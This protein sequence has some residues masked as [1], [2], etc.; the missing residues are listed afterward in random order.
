[1]KTGKQQLDDIYK[2]LVHAVFTERW[3]KE[4]IPAIRNK[5]ASGRPNFYPNYRALNQLRRSDKEIRDK[6][7]P[8]AKERKIK[9]DATWTG[10]KILDVVYEALRPEPYVIE[11]REK[12]GS[13][14]LDRLDDWCAEQAHVMADRSE[15]V[16]SREYPCAECGVMH[17][18]IWGHGGLCRVCLTDVA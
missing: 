17:I 16:I 9:L 18:P 3:D 11:R 13:R 2:A 7:S 4:P 5:K 1:M 15:S 8:I 6:V 12:K 10:K 14:T